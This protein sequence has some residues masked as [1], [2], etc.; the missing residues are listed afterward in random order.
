MAK[1]I[2]KP[3]AKAA[4]KPIVK[5]VAKKIGS[6]ATI[7]GKRLAK[8]NQARF[9]ASKIEKLMHGGRFITTLATG[10]PTRAI[11]KAAERRI[12]DKIRKV[13]ERT[14]E[15]YLQKKQRKRQPAPPQKKLTGAG[16]WIILSL[17]IINELLDILLNFTVVLS[18]LTWI[19]GLIITFV[20][21]FY[22]FYQGVSFSTKKIALWLIS[23]LIEAIPILNILPTYPISL[24]IMRIMENNEFIKSKTRLIGGAIE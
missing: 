3:I 7:E 1:A 10:G 19:T 4:A 18:I 8:L 11:K 2:I 20:I 5:K 22:L 17:S 24:I 9:S 23:I 21:G 14:A 6:E 12:R 16:F 15:K 13:G